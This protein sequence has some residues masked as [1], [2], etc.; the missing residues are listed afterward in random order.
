MGTR[1]RWGLRE[2]G[3]A[4]RYMPG[5]LADREIHDAACREELKR[6]DPAERVIGKTPRLR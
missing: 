4:L 1:E 2:L 5:L 6:Q 3:R